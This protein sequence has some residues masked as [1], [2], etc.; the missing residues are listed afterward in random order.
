M[1]LAE[2]F[3]TIGLT[4]DYSELNFEDL[5]PDLQGW[6]STNAVFQTAFEMIKPLLVFEVGTWKGASLC[7]MASLAK[8]MEL[9]TEFICID[10]WLGSNAILWTNSDFRK[11]LMLKGGYPTMFRQFIKNIHSWHIEDRVYPLPMTSSSAHHL[12]QH[13][14]IV[15]DLIYIDAGHE[16][17]EVKI[18]LQLY[19]GSL[20]PG[21]VLFGDDYS[22]IWPGVVAAVN[23]FVADNKLMLFCGG[24]NFLVQKPG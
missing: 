2:K 17:E 7:H 10:T 9:P 12:L 15:P 24:G 21:G 4:R 14:K 6:G 1:N 8:K 11:S 23:R 13:L 18:D 20:R 3:K 19:Y 16:E 5:A 22:L